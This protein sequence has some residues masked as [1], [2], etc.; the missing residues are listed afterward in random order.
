MILNI[1]RYL[2]LGG[3]LALLT[4]CGAVNGPAYCLD[5]NASSYECL[6]DDWACYPNGFNGVDPSNPDCNYIHVSNESCAEVC[7]AV[8][9][10]AAEGY[11]GAAAIATGSPDDSSSSDENSV[12][13][14]SSYCTNGD[15]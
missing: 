15:I 8:I 9:R 10:C 5:S 4:A 6:V 7:D 14:F 2:L 11:Q 1:S 13:L 3:P 12:M